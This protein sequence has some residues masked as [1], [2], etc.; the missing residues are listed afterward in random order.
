MNKKTIGVGGS[1]AAQELEKI[2]LMTQGIEAISV[3]EYLTRIKKLQSLMQEKGVD[4]IYIDAGTNLYYFTGVYWYPSERLVGALI[5]VS[6]NIQYLVPAFEKG[7]F[8]GM[9]LIDGDIHC[10]HEDEC[11]YHL[12]A[13]VVNKNNPSSKVIALDDATPYFRFD[14]I[15]NANNHHKFINGSSLIGPCRRSKSDAELALMQRANDITLEVHKAA[16]RILKRG[17]TTQQVTQ[18][19]NEAHKAAGA[20]SGSDFCIVLFGE[21]TQYPH[22][23]KSPKAL[24]DNDVVLID[25][26]CNLM[27]YRSDITRCYIFGEPNDRQRQI[28]DYEKQAQAEAYSAIVIGEE[29]GN[30]DK[31]VR[32]YLLTVDLGPDYELPGVPHRTGHGIGLNIHEAPNLVRND[33]TLLEKG[34]CFSVEPMICMPGEFGIRLEDHVYITETGP[35]WFTEP[36]HTIDD[37]F[38]YEK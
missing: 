26:G 18:F 5:H 22:G 2:Q 31:A 33:T 37:P 24:E 4:Y 34:M 8:S 1:T 30:A 6:G 35:K 11:P 28:W 17:I 32:D 38:G 21:D 3:N 7:T 12:F 19:I 25:T 16:A 29:C 9:M 27:G 20:T 10:W 13:S 36:C 23:V 15:N 14:G